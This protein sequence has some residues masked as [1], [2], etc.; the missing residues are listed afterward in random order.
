MY[1][2]F[3]QATGGRLGREGEEPQ[4]PGEEEGGN[5]EEVSRY[6]RGGKSRNRSLLRRCCRTKE[7]FLLFPPLLV[8]AES[9]AQLNAIAE[10]QAREL[11]TLKVGSMW[12]YTVAVNLS[13]SFL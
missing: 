7:P 9:L 13:P 11:G 1:V 8:F 5:R 10:Q 4:G 6:V 3:V 2:C 12:Y